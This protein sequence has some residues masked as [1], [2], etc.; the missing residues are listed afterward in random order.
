MD[1][2]VKTTVY[3]TDISQFV[4]VN[5]VYSEFFSS[6]PPARGVIEASNLPKNAKVAVEAVIAIG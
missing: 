2:A 5:E 4:A 6:E 1:H 3:L